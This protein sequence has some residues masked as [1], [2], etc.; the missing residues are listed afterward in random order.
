MVSSSLGQAYLRIAP[1]GNT[2]SRNAKRYFQ[3]QARSPVGDTS[4]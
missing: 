3:R 2:F 1:N 4:T